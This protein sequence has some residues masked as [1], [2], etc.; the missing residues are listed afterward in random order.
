MK[1]RSRLPFQLTE[2][3]GLAHDCRL[4]SWC[5]QSCLFARSKQMCGH[6][7]AHACVH[8]CF[9]E[10]TSLMILSGVKAIVE[11]DDIVRGY[12]LRPVGEGRRACSM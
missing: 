4:P 8:V 12:G 6:T 11:I 2:A 9:M 7:R 3:M 5:L 10:Y 1:K